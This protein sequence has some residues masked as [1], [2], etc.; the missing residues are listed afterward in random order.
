MLL[1]TTSTSLRVGIH[2]SPLLC[3]FLCQ[4]LRAHVCVRDWRVVD[5]SG[6]A[7][8]PIRCLSTADDW[9]LI[10]GPEISVLEKE[11]SWRREASKRN[12]SHLVPFLWQNICVKLVMR[13]GPGFFHMKAAIIPEIAV[14]E[15]TVTAAFWTCNRRCLNSIKTHKVTLFWG[16]WWRTR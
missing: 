11:L 15:H 7:F 9:Q 8:S 13:T 6:T 5:L 16:V 14:F 12:R 2:T 10:C 3:T 1:C 4:W